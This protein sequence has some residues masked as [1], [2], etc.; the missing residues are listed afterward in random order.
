MMILWSSQNVLT[1][2]QH[3][4]IPKYNDKNL[5]FEIVH[6]I[7]APS[8]IFSPQCRGPAAFS[9]PAQQHKSYQLL[10]RLN[11]LEINAVLLSEIL[12]TLEGSHFSASI[13]YI[14][15]HLSHEKLTE[16]ICKTNFKKNRFRIN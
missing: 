10:I 12:K 1:L 14:I 6:K 5:T 4:N 15:R 11:L 16:I 13:F 9:S 3:I 2:M 8:E 7:E